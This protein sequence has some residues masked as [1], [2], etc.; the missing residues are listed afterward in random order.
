MHFSNMFSFDLETKE[1]N[2]CDLQ[3]GVPRWNHCSILVEAIP[4]FSYK[5]FIFGG[6]CADYQEGVA[7]AF[8]AYVNSSAYLE[9]DKMN[10]SIFASDP[11]V[12]PNMPEP[13]EYAGMA[14]QQNDRTLVLF[15]GWSNGWHS[16]VYTLN[17][18]KVVGPP[19]AITGAEPNMG[20][21]TGGNTLRIFGKNFSEYNPDQTPVYFTAGNKPIDNYNPEK[22]KY[23]KVAKGVFV[24]ENEITVT[25]PDMSMYDVGNGIDCI[26]QLN[27]GSSDITTTY[28]DFNYYLNTRAGKSLVFGPG[29]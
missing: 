29:V 19:Y 4:N 18:A 22:S 17:V 2:D 21:L 8:G 16:D 20:Q 15:G 27:L 7:R 10:W 26:V 5:F 6:E 14:Y 12:F 9:V 1:W 25:T 23:T 13:R 11:D 28:V 24:S 3:F